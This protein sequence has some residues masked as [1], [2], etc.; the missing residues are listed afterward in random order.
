M[1]NGSQAPEKD[2]LEAVKEKLFP[3]LP[4]SGK[5]RITLYALAQLGG[6]ISTRSLAQTA[7]KLL[8]ASGEK[9]FTSRQ[10]AF[11]KKI[12]TALGFGARNERVINLDNFYGSDGKKMLEQLSLLA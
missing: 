7:G 6:E 3:E 10:L 2:Y 1:I 11:A 8:E 4:D 9:G 12:L 5:V